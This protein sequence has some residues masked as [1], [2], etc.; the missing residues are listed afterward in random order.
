MTFIVGPPSHPNARYSL[1]SHLVGCYTTPYG[2]PSEYHTVLFVPTGPG[3]AWTGPAEWGPLM[4]YLAASFL[5]PDLS[6]LVVSLSIMLGAHASYE[7]LQQIF[8]TSTIQVSLASLLTQSP[9]NAPIPPS[10]LSLPLKSQPVSPIP[11]TFILTNHLN[12]EPTSSPTLSTLTVSSLYSALPTTGSSRKLPLI[13]P[14]RSL[15]LQ[16]SSLPVATHRRARHT[17]FTTLVTRL[18]A[19]MNSLPYSLISPRISRLA[20]LMFIRAPVFSSVTLLPY[21]PG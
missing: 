15:T 5:W 13:P 8:D 2:Y 14:L 20:K 18:R 6:F 3:Q 7:E 21:P 10:A 19:L 4:V 1:H 17:I 11:P 9:L 16:I 12:G